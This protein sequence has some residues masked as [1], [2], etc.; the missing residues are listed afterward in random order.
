[1]DKK[2]RSEKLWCIVQLCDLDSGQ[3]RIKFGWIAVFWD[4][5]I[6]KIGLELCTDVRKWIQKSERGESTIVR[7]GGKPWTKLERGIV[8]PVSK[9]KGQFRLQSLEKTKIVDNNKTC[10]SHFNIYVCWL[11]SDYINTYTFLG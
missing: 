3:R 5:F 10:H 9:E 11:I 4:A 2:T 7:G 8:N 1:M 6:M